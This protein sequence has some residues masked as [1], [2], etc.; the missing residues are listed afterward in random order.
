[1][2]TIL[3]AQICKKPVISIFITDRGFG[4]AAVFKSKSCIQINSAE[5]EKTLKMLFDDAEYR[6]KVIDS[7]TK[8][9]N[10]YLS[11]QGTA[12]KNLLSFLES[13]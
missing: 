3:E 9:S 6:Q 4:D 7:G 10:E 5:L 2:T 11:N 1:S 13:F 8:F 12:S